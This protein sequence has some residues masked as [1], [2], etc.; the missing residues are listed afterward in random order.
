[1]PQLFTECLLR[2]QEAPVGEDRL[3]GLAQ[4]RS[5]F[6]G[7]EVVE[8]RGHLACPPQA[9][10]NRA[11]KGGVTA[12]PPPLAPAAGLALVSQWPDFTC[13]FLSPTPAGW[14][15]DFRSEMFA[16]VRYGRKT[17][18]VFLLGVS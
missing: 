10:E 2:A 4:G 3:T 17:Q 1:M 9:F 14:L 12:G 13:P 8:S 11:A 16:P 7:Q 6:S 18:T 5:A 15:S